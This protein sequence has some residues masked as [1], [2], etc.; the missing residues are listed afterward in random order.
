MSRWSH[1]AIS[2]IFIILG[3]VPAGN[4]HPSSSHQ[5]WC[6]AG[7]TDPF[8]YPSPGFVLLSGMRPILHLSWCLSV[9]LHTRCSTHLPKVHPCKDTAVGS[10][11]FNPNTPHSSVYQKKTWLLLVLL[12]R[13]LYYFSA[14]YFPFSQLPFQPRLAAQH[15]C[16]ILFPFIKCLL[17]IF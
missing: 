16:C 3:S 1:L 6:T 9:T 12:K 11:G 7:F 17:Y 5:C 10:S 2:V 8:L 14:W 13:F 4:S 15:I